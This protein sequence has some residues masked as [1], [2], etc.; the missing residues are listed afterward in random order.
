MHGRASLRAATRMREFRTYRSARRALSG[1]YN[2]LVLTGTA[3]GPDRPS[4]Q[5]AFTSGSF[6]LSTDAHG[7]GTDIR[8]ICFCAGT[9]IGTPGGEVPVE[10]LKIGDLVLSAHTGRARSPG[11][12]TARCSPR[13]AGA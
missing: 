2:T 11:S 9:M 5:G 13:V 10:K 3:G 8:V 12:A 1:G 6:H 7:D 4:I